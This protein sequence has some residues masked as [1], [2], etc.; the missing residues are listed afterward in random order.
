[1]S[2]S[3]PGWFCCGAWWFL[4]FWFWFFFP[5][6]LIK[7]MLWEGKKQKMLNKKLV[8]NSAGLFLLPRNFCRDKITGPAY[9]LIIPWIPSAWRL[10]V[11]H[12]LISLHVIFKKNELNLKECLPVGCSC[13]YQPVGMWPGCCSCAESWWSHT[14]PGPTE[15]SRKPPWCHSQSFGCTIPEACA[16]EGTL[17]YSHMAPS[18]HSWHWT[19][20][21]EIFAFAFV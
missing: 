8:G 15:V 1:M 14:S 7:L 5:L 4:G 3:H 18:G 9:R 16:V 21:L 13:C 19:E 20:Q 12:K 11:V 6:V 2:D 17:F 10:Q